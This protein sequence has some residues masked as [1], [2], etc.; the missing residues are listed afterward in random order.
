MVLNKEAIHE[1]KFHQAKRGYSE[2]EVDAFLD[3]L[4]EAV[5]AQERQIQAEREELAKFRSMEKDLA[6]AL[7]MAQNTAKSL[8][9]DARVRANA[10]VLQA[11]TQAEQLRLQA[12]EELIAARE[13]YQGEKDALLERLSQLRTFVETYQEHIQLD[14]KNQL[15][16]FE[17]SFLSEATW[18]NAPEEA[19]EAEQPAE[20]AEQP[21]LADEHIPSIDL[22]E[23][24]KNLPNT[25]VELKA[26]ID[27]II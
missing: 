19:K 5:E 8:E 23:I 6:N 13:Q 21:A 2:Q 11:Q 27:E 26:L 22:G 14:M 9:E 12:E 1:K 7:V 25:D 16:A 15:A 18:E 4:A 20:E 3:E 10:T 17:Q 24:M